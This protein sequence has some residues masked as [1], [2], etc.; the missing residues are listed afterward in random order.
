MLQSKGNLSQSGGQTLGY[1]I[2]ASLKADRQQRAADV[3]Q[4]IETLLSR[5]D[6]EEGLV[7]RSR[8][9]GIKALL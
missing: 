5:G 7:L 2:K 1:Q 8:G 9:P 4:Q 3:G 6:P